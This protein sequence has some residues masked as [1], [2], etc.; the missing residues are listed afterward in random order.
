MSE[1]PPTAQ[2]GPSARAAA[3]ARLW[4]HGRL[5][6]EDFP[7]GQLDV[8]LAEPDSLA[9]VDLV[10]PDPQMLAQLAEELG[11][12]PQ[13]VDATLAHRE[14]P[15]AIRHGDRV[16]LTM[17]ATS[18]TPPSDGAFAGAHESRLELAKI[19]VFALPRAL[20]TIRPDERF[21]MAEVTARWDDNAALIEDT[22]GDG[23]GALLHGL[24][25]AVVDSHFDTIQQLDDAVEAIEDVL[26]D[27]DVRT[28]Q[29]Q[30]STYRI[31]KELVELRR[32]VLP[33]RE[34]VNGVL[35]HRTALPEA[36]RNAPA[37]ALLRP[38]YD[39]LYD[40]VLRAAEWTESLRDMVTSLF[41]TNLSLQDARLNTVMK[42]LA[43]WAA[44]IA[45][46]TAV[47]G[48][49]GQKVPYPGFQEVSGLWQSVAL[50]VIGSLGLYVVFK[51][52]DWL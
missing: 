48:W 22:G 9:W 35:R 51:R 28:A 12:T 42:K 52:R 43:A 49:F 47:T 30:R 37:E 34:L 40:H 3:R 10:A 39:D 33:M 41:E 11:M 26:F 46:P 38:W 36:E 27:T 24:L 21:D 44:I 8:H 32:V 31:R 1:S 45:V 25:D 4:R 2:P 16:F 15:K 19:S 14:R 6:E 23:M 7:L 29:V 20:V 50:V 13:A 5:A 17:Y 18:L